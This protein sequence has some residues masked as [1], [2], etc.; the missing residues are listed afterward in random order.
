MA[1]IQRTQNIRDC[2][3]SSHLSE[4]TEEKTGHVEGPKEPG[5]RGRAK[6]GVAEEPSGEATK[7]LH[8]Q[9]R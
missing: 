1:D 9:I 8:D 6:V 7:T 2:T 5:G 3:G 4:R